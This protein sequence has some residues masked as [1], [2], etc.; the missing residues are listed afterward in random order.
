MELIISDKIDDKTIYEVKV[1]DLEQKFIF[2]RPSEYYFI[3]RFKQKYPKLKFDQLRIE[4]IKKL[5]E[6]KLKL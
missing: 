3:R 5:G 6:T 1:N 2:S 4:P